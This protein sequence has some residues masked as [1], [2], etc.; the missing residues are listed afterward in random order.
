MIW[1]VSVDVQGLTQTAGMPKPSRFHAGRSVLRFSPG[2]PLW[3]PGSV[4][5]SVS[6]AEDGDRNANS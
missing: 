3:R 4:I 6:E 5:Q 1:K 2:C